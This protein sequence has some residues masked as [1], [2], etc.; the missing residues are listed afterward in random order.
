MVGFFVFWFFFK[1][2]ARKHLTKKMNPIVIAGNA[3]EE[4]RGSAALEE[5]VFTEGPTRRWLKKGEQK[6]QFG[7]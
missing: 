5:D 4:E 2:H 6:E 7:S 1:G 3:E